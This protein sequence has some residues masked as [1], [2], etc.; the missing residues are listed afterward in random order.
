[1]KV[2]RGVALALSLIRG[3]A[4]WEKR[5]PRRRVKAW[6]GL[7][8]RGRR[9]YMATHA[10]EARLEV[11]AVLEPVHDCLAKQ[12]ALRARADESPQRSDGEGVVRS[13]PIRSSSIRSDPIRSDDEG[14][15]RVGGHARLDCVVH[16]P[17]PLPAQPR[18]ALI[19]AR[20]RLEPRR[21]RGCRCRRLGCRG[22]RLG[23]RG[24]GGARGGTGTGCGVVCCGG[25]GGGSHR[26]MPP[27][28]CFHR[29]R[30]RRRRR[31]ALRSHRRG[32]GDSGGIERGVWHERRL[33]MGKHGFLCDVEALARVGQESRQSA[34]EVEDLCTEIW[35]DM[36]R[37]GEIWGD[38]GRYGEIW[39]G[40]GPVHGRGGV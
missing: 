6:R 7:R 1:M 35:G 25:C 23:C 5:G 33:V 14:L 11:Q 36:G 17:P 39:G 2:R 10:A 31:G 19:A 20:A 13:D 8:G 16:L 4:P 3:A 18:M 24:R 15:V 9:Q 34:R 30:R 32:G 37:Y 12:E 29:R 28:R 21:D 38:M 22:R 40:G 27:R 26:H